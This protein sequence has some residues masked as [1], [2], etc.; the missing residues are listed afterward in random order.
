MSPTLRLSC[1]LVGGTNLLVRCADV[2]LARGHRI[3]AIVT[4]DADVACGI[5]VHRSIGDAM[6]ALEERPDV[7]FSIVNGAI[8]RPDEISYA[9]RA[10]VNYHDAPLP[11]YAGVNAPSWAILNGESSHG[12]TWHLLTETVDAGDI[13]VQR[14]FSVAPDDTALSLSMKCFEHALAAFPEVLGMLED[15]RPRGMP[16][17]L[18]RRT[19]F[20][21]TR[22][23]PRQGIIRWTDAAAEICRCVRAG[24]LGPYANDFGL[25][26]ILLG[27]RSIVAVA[28]AGLVD[29]PVA[30]PA[31]TVVDVGLDSLSVATGDGLVLRVQGLT[32]SDGRPFEAPATLRGSV[33]PMLSPAVEERVE[34]ATVMS[35][36]AEDEVRR[37]LRDMPAPLRPHGLRPGRFPDAGEHVVMRPCER[38]RTP[39]EVFAPILAR[40]A[41]E[42]GVRAFTVG[43][44]HPASLPGFMAVQP[45]ACRDTATDALAVA[46]ERA[47]A[48]PMPA[49]IALRFPDLRGAAAWNAA[50]AV[51][52]VTQENPPLANPGLVI[53]HTDG[54]LIFR[55]A[56]GQASLSDAERIVASLCGEPS[57]AV[58]TDGS[59]GRAVQDHVARWAMVTPDAIAVEDAGGTLSYAA[60]ERQSAGLASRLRSS[61]AASETLVA[62]LLPQGRDFV[63]A[64]LAV[65]RSGAAYL[66]LDTTTPVHRLREIVHDAMPLGVI[67][68][69]ARREVAAQLGTTIIPMDAEEPPATA[70]PPTVVSADDLAYV[71]YTS[72]STGE[73]KGSM[74]EHGALSHFIEA[75]IAR[76]GIGP[77]DRVLQLCSVAF[78]AAVEEM[79]SALCA[80]ATLVVRSATLLDSARD[81]LDFCEERGLTIIGIYAAMLGGVCAE[82]QRRDRFPPTVRLVTTGGEAVRAGDAERWRAFWKDRIARPPT[83]LNVYGLTETTVANCTSDLGVPP[84]LPGKVP[85]GRPL[86]GNRVRVVGAGLAAVGTGEIGELLIAG[87]QLAR[88][89]WNRPSLDTVRFVIDPT[90]GTRWCRTGDLVRMAP[91]GELYFEG[92][93]DRQVKVQGVRIELG[94]VESAMLS[95]PDVTQAAA[96]VC[97]VADGREILAA[98]FSASRVGLECDVRRH[99]ESRVPA[100]MVPRRVVQIDAFPVNDRGKID[101]RVLGELLG[102]GTAP[103]GATGT[104]LEAAAR[105]LWKEV[106][107]WSDSERPDESFF[108]LGGD[109]LTA[110]HLLL[111]VEQELDVHVPVSSFFTDPTLGG[112]LRLLGT[113]YGDPAFDQ[114]ITL[115]PDGSGTPIYMLHGGSGDITEYAGLVRRLG[116]GRQILGVRSQTVVGRG[117]L[118]DSFEQMAAELVAA[119]RAHRPDGGWIL[120]GYSMAGMLAYETARQLHGETG[121]VPVVI[122]IDSLA[123]LTRFSVGERLRHFFVHLPGWLLAAG[124]LRRF[125][126]VRSALLGSPAVKRDATSTA[127]RRARHFFRL[128]EEYRPPGDRRLEIE[129]VR[130]SVHE[131]TP[132]FPDIHYG[133]KDNGWSKATGCVVR[134][135]ALEAENRRALLREPTCREVAAL[136]QTVSLVA[137]DHDP[138]GGR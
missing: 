59:S 8:L 10:A 24:Q 116:A 57:M 33:L 119:I 58:A 67:H 68:D 125:R 21:R 137:D 122:M 35:A 108:D 12:V 2:L 77:G 110:V 34:A 85:I 134:V 64:V 81:F 92:R 126:D 88:A 121:R 44:V 117:E 26:K 93:V 52:L 76:H 5:R 79:F 99:L 66:P 75:D 27:D 39:G 131:M 3:V 124:W 20:G 136:I 97:R 113:S 45:C 70:P 13:L 112:F 30:A 87:P 90:D 96:L 48:A 25:P 16:Q 128:A 54:R 98:C 127:A 22:R 82:M 28:R 123:P 37:S 46:I 42:R 36:R 40:M 120:V 111:R 41:S 102:R 15:G 23:L 55:F 49:D 56:A 73:P 86:P 129:L 114:L 104:G 94:D 19:V 106:F 32:R 29:V 107:P 135:H 95:H 103:T 62:I 80:G 65:L 51:C 53:C 61:G 78:D 105:R 91:G 38:G 132:L 60:L 11:A 130:A 89:Y 4:D 72:G 47:R 1:L 63:A 83:F 50:L 9:T 18:T 6:G 84:E 100:A 31:G 133:W 115:Q 109:S 14:R 43:V 69:E 7:V 74:I 17:D 138:D 71:I 118:P 101:Q